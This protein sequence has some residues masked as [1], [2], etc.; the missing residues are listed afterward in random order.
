MT[1][2]AYVSFYPPSEK[3]SDSFISIV[4]KSGVQECVDNCIAPG[5]RATN[6]EHTVVCLPPQGDGGGQ[7]PNLAIW[8][9]SRK[10]SSGLY[11]K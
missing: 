7:T 5:V 11:T 2:P 10:L 9:A 4:E 8:K 3:K 1:T 6:S